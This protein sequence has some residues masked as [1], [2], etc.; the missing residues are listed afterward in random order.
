[1]LKLELYIKMLLDNLVELATLFLST[2]KLS[3]KSI[4]IL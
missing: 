3:F 1:M 4:V 2:L